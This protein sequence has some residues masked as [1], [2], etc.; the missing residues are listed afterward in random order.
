M[1]I[2]LYDRNNESITLQ[3]WS[4]LCGDQK[5]VTV[6]ESQ[7][8]KGGGAV[9][10]TWVGYHPLAERGGSVPDI[11][12]TRAY[13]LDGGNLVSSP[14][15]EQFTRHAGTETEA[16][17]NHKDTMGRINEALKNVTLEEMAAVARVGGGG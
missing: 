13:A 16:Q 10:T 15:L 8:G 4:Q 9:I 1:E 6:A 7:I 5:Y 11:F 2:K 17:A 14:G 3:Q 12:E